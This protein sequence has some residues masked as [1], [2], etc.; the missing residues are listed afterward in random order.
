MDGTLRGAMLLGIERKGDCTLLKLGTTTFKSYYRGSPFIK[1]IIASLTLSELIK[2]PLTPIFTIGKV[3]SPKGYVFG[4]SMTEFHPI[5]NRETPEQYKKIFAEFA[6]TYISSKPG[7]ARYNP[8]TF[9]I[10]Q[11]DSSVAEN[12]AVLSEHELQNP[13]IKFFVDR[14]P[15]WKKV[16]CHPL[17]L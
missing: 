5:Y 12:L 17:V 2:H 9:V 15:G 7:R 1:I 8:E 4:L 14:N 3:Y 10:E 13:H 6:E 11:E 16:N